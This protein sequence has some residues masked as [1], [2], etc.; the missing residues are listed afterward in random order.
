MVS[1]FRVR[2]SVS[3]FAIQHYYEQNMNGIHNSDS[4]FRRFWIAKSRVL[5][6]SPTIVTSANGIE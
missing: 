4:I 2:S 5:R 3:E 6:E 1:E